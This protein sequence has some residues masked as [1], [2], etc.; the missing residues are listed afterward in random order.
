ML[1]YVVSGDVARP[2]LLFLHGFLGNRHD[3]EQIVEVLKPHALCIRVDLPGHGL[4]TNVA[5]TTFDDVADAVVEVLDAESIDA[6]IL[7][8][9]SMG[10]RIALYTALRHPSRFEGLVLESATAGIA[11]A[12]ERD[13]RLQRDKG[14]AIELEE[15]EFTAFLR[16]WYSQ[17]LFASLSKRPDLLGAMLVRREAQEPKALASA[18]HAFCQGVQPSLWD[19]LKEIDFPVLLIAGEEDRKYMLVAKSMYG[20]LLEHDRE[21]ETARVLRAANGR[22]HAVHIVPACGHNVHL[23]DPATFSAHLKEFVVAGE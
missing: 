2:C 23:E 13:V 18:L 16:W 5:A 11:N 7:V 19:R 21:D 22:T 12:A 1:H 17:P 6:A 8:G 15:M 10:G 4:S 9:Y 14:L 20:R 3:W